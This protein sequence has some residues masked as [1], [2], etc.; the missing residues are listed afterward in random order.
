MEAK[1]KTFVVKA[2]ATDL[3]ANPEGK[4]TVEE[5]Q[6]VSKEEVAVKTFG[7]LKKRDGDRLLAVGRR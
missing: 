6:E 5:Q 1:S 7:A 2:E 3:E 4:D